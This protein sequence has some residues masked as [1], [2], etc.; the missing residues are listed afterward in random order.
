LIYADAVRNTV[1]TEVRAFRDGMLG[2]PDRLSM[3]I[4]SEHDA[5]KIRLILSTEFDRELDRLAEA[6]Q[7][8]G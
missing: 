4:A 3:T 8:V 2:L 6:L 7:T 1:T 5:R